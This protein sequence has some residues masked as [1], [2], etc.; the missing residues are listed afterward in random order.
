M[1]S[2]VLKVLFED[3]LARAKQKYDFDII[4]FVIMGNHFHIIIKPG[5]QECLSKIMQWIMSVF[6]MNYNRQY[7]CWGHFWGGRFISRIIESLQQYLRI[8]E[9][10][11][12]NPV[13]AGLVNSRTEW[14]YGGLAHHRQGKRYIATELPLFLKLFFPDHMQLCLPS[15]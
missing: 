12:N 7:D 3:I 9:Y 15:A 2:H 8:F 14:K 10:I 5:K 4:N 13:K 11:D 1:D 6:A